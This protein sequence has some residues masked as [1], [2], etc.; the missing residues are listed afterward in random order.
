M[1]SNSNIP[2]PCSSVTVIL[3]R[4]RPAPDNVDNTNNIES[5]KRRMAGGINSVLA[6]VRNSKMKITVAQNV[7][8]DLIKKQKTKS[9]VQNTIS[10]DRTPKLELNEM[11]CLT[12]GV[13]QIINFIKMFPNVQA[14]YEVYG[15]FGTQICTSS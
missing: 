10:N 15:K 7:D 6:L 2:K 5:S 1:E 4:K 8:N 9:I 11:R 12:G 13:K 3:P 14:L